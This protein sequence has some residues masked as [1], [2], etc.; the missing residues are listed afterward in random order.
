MFFMGWGGE[1]EGVG[2][3]LL[4]SFQY[5]ISMTKKGSFSSE[6]S[7]VYIYGEIDEKWYTFRGAPIYFLL[8]S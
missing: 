1:W 3:F 4:N 2:L 8:N 7:R 6:N 5:S